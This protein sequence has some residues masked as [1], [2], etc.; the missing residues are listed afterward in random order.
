M[1]VGDQCGKAEEA[2]ELY[3]SAFEGSRVI[4]VERFGPEDEG[5]RASSTRALRWRAVR[6]W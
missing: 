3:V 6:S 2:M 4:A 5:E 1:L